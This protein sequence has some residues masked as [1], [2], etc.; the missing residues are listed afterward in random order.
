MPYTLYDR[1]SSHPSTP[2]TNLYDVCILGHGA[3]GLAFSKKHPLV[4]L[5]LSFSP[6]IVSLL[7]PFHAAEAQQIPVHSNPL[8]QKKL[9]ASINKDDMSDIPDEDDIDLYTEEERNQLINQKIQQVHDE[10][11][12][13]VK[14]K[15]VLIMGY[16]SCKTKQTQTHVV[17]NM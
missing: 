7:L 12:P 16:S 9:E 15:R 10:L 14:N 4:Q 6:Q 3:G 5:C 2:S 8:E 13:L 17:L 1:A 11:L